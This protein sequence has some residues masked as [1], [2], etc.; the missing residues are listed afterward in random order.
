MAGL[1][2]KGRMALR[3]HSPVDV[4]PPQ[5]AP[6]TTGKKRLEGGKTL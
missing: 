2:K 5:G 6:Y 3:R 1:L 4:P